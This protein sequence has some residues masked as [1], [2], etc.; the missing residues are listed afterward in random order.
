MKLV[1][2]ADDWTV[3]ASGPIIEDIY[4][5]LN[6][7]LN[8]LAAWYADRH[9]AL[10]STKSSATL[11]TTS[12]NEIST[13]LEISING[14]TIPTVKR[15]RILGGMF[16]N[17]LPFGHHAMDIRTRV[18]KRTNILKALAG[19]TWGKTKEV[20]TT[21]YKAIGRSLMSY[22]A[23]IWAPTTSNTNWDKLQAAQNAALRCIT[24]CHL[25]THRDHLHEETRI[26]PVKQHGDLL[27]KQFLVACHHPEH[28]N[29]EII[30]APPP[31][32]LMRET[33][34]SKYNQEVAPQLPAASAPC[35]RARSRDRSRSARA[36]P[37]RGCSTSLGISP[38]GLL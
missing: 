10:S 1:T 22:A 27:A 33:L 15:P 14:E 26:L 31:P 35:S 7:Y 16:D 37:R 5:P 18:G 19:T 30:A 20:L 28:P 25:M 13:N 29:H 12:T 23:P 4:P 38:L 8:T 6:A 9:L 17:M 32:R 21:T 2:Y 34:T 36:R 3:L 24:G 11:F